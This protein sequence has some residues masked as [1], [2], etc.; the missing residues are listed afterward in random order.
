MTR[1]IEF[2]FD[3]GSPTT[4]LAHRRIAGIVARTGAVVDYVPVL[5]GA[6]FKATGNASPVAVPA[7]RR[8]MATDMSRFARRHGID[9]AVNPHFPINTIALMRGATAYRGTASY[10]RYVETM[11]DAMW[12]RPVDLGN[13]ESVADVL[14][15][16]GFDP[17]AFVALNAKDD[18][19]ETLKATTEAAIERGVFGAPTF[20]V[21][22]EMFFGQDRLDWVEAAV[23]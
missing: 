10:G 13:P 19:K 11:F 14:T 17:A 8:Y 5:L 3:F 12:A 23:A 2:L 22:D 16:A 20:F 21:D 18:V 1:T 4:F 6:I 7:K 9:L 15:A